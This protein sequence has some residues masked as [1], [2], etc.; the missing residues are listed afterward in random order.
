MAKQS[1]SKNIIRIAPQPGPQEQFLRSAADWVIYGGAAGGGKTYGLLLECLRHCSNP[2]FGAV[3]FRQSF[4]QVMEEGAL[5]DTSEEIYP[6]MGAQPKKANLDWI[7]PSGAKIGFAHLARD[8]DKFKYQGAQ[9]PLI[10]MDELTHF[11]ES[12]VFYLLSRNRSTSGVRPY[13]RGTTNPDADSWIA[14]FISWWIDD[15]G[16]AIAER[17]GVVRWFVRH[18]G[19]IAWASDPAQLTSRYPELMPKSFTFIKSTIHDNQI[20]LSKDPGYL[21]NLL[22]LHPLDQ[23]RLLLGNWKVRAE[24][25][26]VFN[27]TWFEVVE[28]DAVAPGFEVRFWDLAATEAEVRANAC[29][30]AGVKMRAVYDRDGEVTFYIMDCIAEQVGP[31][32]GDAL[33]KATAQQDGRFCLVR[34]EQEGGSSGKRDEAHI[35]EMLPGFDAMGVPPQ[36]DKVVR[37]KP[38][39]TDAYLGR[40]KLVRGG[41]NDQ[42]LNWMHSFPDG[43]IKDVTDASSGAHACLIDEMHLPKPGFGRYN[44]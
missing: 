27:R 14:D 29:Y 3:I 38:L 17:S 9:I 36:G 24:A 2:R 6:L 7:F 26:K 13:F 37:A 41:W 16:F 39:A 32:G 1:K 5:W 12:A 19:E 44:Y 43:K 25:G 11:P 15:E 21:G 30:T 8:Q 20:L 33:M 4:A 42:Y 34:W 35:Q 40:V 10:C 28:A 18:R 22:A 31:A 23:A